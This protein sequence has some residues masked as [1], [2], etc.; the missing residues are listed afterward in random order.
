ML[1]VFEGWWKVLK[2]EFFLKCICLFNCSCEII[3]GVLLGEEKLWMIVCL[4]W[5]MSTL[6]EPF[7]NAEFSEGLNIWPVGFIDE[8]KLEKLL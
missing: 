8:D 4:D 2:L 3:F 5:S 7:L 1:G 6:G